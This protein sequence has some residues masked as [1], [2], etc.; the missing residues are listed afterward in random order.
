MTAAV[1]RARDASRYEAP[2]RAMLRIMRR[3]AIPF[4]SGTIVFHT[5][6]ATRLNNYTLAHKDNTFPP[7]LKILT[8]SVIS[9]IS[10]TVL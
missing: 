9:V 7:N 10:C 1:S 6:N 2:L 4:T 5:V 3:R 8:F